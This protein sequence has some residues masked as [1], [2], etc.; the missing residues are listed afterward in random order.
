MKSNYGK[1]RA[2]IPWDVYE[3]Y[4]NEIGLT[5]EENSRV[6]NLITSTL[7]VSYTIPGCNVIERDGKTRGLKW[8]ELMLNAVGERKKQGITITDEVVKEL[9]MGEPG[10]QMEL[11]AMIQVDNFLEAMH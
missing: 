5:D 9:I 2:R 8:A 3:N 4:M 11:D 7:E 1:K 6:F 10:I